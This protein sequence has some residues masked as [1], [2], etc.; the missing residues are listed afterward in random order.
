[1]LFPG[2]RGLPTPYW[3][4]CGSSRDAIRARP[5]ERVLSDEDL[6]QAEAAGNSAQ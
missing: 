2:R 3:T 1:L 4:S 5:D 6:A